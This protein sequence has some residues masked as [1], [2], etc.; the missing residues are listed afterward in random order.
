MAQPL[1]QGNALAYYVAHIRFIICVDTNY[2]SNAMILL[3]YAQA[4]AACHPLSSFTLNQAIQLMMMLLLLMRVCVALNT[5]QEESFKTIIGVVIITTTTTQ[6][7]EVIGL[8]ARFA[9]R[10][11]LV[12]T[13]EA[14]STISSRPAHE[15]SLMA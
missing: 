12:A 11:A 8:V 13:Q 1:A 6:R 3:L 10:A 9:T 5:L 14:N 15:R 7:T 4:R 2:D